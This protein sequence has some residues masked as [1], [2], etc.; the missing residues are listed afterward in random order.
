MVQRELFG[1]FPAKFIG[2]KRRWHGLAPLAGCDTGFRSAVAETDFSPQPAGS[3]ARR[4]AQFNQRQREQA[5]QADLPERSPTPR[6]LCEALN[7][8]RAAHRS[9]EHTS[10]LQSHHDLVCRLLLEKKKTK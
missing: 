9:E 2:Q 3:A 10:E 6:R 5:Q 4:S 7:Q 1:H 8:S